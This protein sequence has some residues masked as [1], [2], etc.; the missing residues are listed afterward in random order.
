M[1]KCTFTDPMPKVKFEAVN[2][3]AKAIYNML[4]VLNSFLPENFNFTLQNPA[5][6]HVFEIK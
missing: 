2:Y 1:C 3:K 4:A 6:K 5:E